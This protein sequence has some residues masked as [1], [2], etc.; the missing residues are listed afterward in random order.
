M[1]AEAGIQCLK[2]LD[3]SQKHAGMTRKW[4]SAVTR[5]IADEMQ[6]VIGKIHDQI[7]TIEY[8]SPDNRICTGR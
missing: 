8:I 6:P 5:L 3:P 1:P 2:S 4:D 7:K